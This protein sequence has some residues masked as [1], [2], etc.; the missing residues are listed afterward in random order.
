MVTAIPTS[1][2][3]SIDCFEKE[4]IAKVPVLG[5]I[6]MQRSV[7]KGMIERVSHVV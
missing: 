3:V 4:P 1:T 6:L 7:R 2:R 5:L